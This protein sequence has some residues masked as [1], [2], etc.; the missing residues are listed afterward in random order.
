[1]SDRPPLWLKIVLRVERVVGGRV[2]SA[3]HSDGYF[4]LVAGLNRTKTK[5]SGTIEG[6]SKRVLHVANLPAETDIRRVR[7]QLARVERRVVEL[8]KQLDEERAAREA[9]L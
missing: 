8:S 3:V 6:V 4:D 2:E 9:R 5:V 1:V 7:E